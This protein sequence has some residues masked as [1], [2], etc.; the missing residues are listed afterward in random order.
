MATTETKK[1]PATKTEK[2]PAA[3][4]AAASVKST[5]P[6][7]RHRATMVGTVISN[8]MQKTIV[9]AIGRQVRHTLYGKYVGKTKKYKAHDEKN[10]AKVGDLVSLVQS[11]PLSRDKRWVLR[12]IVRKAEA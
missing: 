10:E 7:V 4:K 6:V 2:K 3:P 5:E 1:K 8:K 11:R 12:Q 9:V